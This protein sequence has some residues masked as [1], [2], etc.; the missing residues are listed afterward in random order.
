VIELCRGLGLDHVV[1]VGHSVSAMIG[2]LAAIAAPELF[3]ALVMVAPSPRYINERSYRGGFDARDIDEMIEVL[4]SNYLGWSAAMA[5]TIVGNLERPELADELSGSFC[6]NDPAI[7]RHFARVTFTGDNRADLPRIKTPT[8]VLQC[9]DDAI[10]P[11]EVGR[12]VHANIAGSR[13]VQLR[14]TG[15]CPN[16]SAPRETADAIRAF[17]RELP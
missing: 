14:A 9:S 3:R 6:R 13:F 5:P 12:Y 7:A 2:A 16:L 11:D 15:H 10:A 1:F 8:L 4:D 17:L